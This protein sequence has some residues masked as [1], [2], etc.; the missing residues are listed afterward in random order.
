MDAK[1]NE[2]KLLEIFILTDDFVKSY[3]KHCLPVRAGQRRREPGLAMSEIMTILIYYHHSGYKC[4]EYYYERCVLKDLRSYFPKTPSYTRFVQLIPR[5]L[6]PLYWM[7]QIL[8]RVAQATGIYFVDS[9]KLPVCHNRRIH[10]NKVFKD[11][12]KR[13]KTSTG[14]FFGLKIHLVINNL[15]EVV[16]F[17]I[18]AGNVVD[19]AKEVLDK[20]LGFI[21]GKC[22][23]DKGYISKYFEHFYEQGVELIT[24][25]RKNMKNKPMQWADKMMLY[26]RA[27][28]ES[29]N[30]ILMTVFDID[31]TRHRSPVNAITHVL[32]AVIAYYFYDA[33][34]A[35][36]N[37]CFLNALCK[38][39]KTH[40]NLKKNESTLIP[41][42]NFNVDL[43]TVTVDD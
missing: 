18:T 16:S 23:G 1:V 13:G 5:C 32:G 21:Y 39:S 22:F 3:K 6:L 27:I 43:W 15:G 2:Q 30:D 7:G 37:P 8:G 24:R 36:F 35:V 12:A 38:L 11:I 9:K 19:N 26:K 10:S 4:F 42:I 41:D 14:W 33:K 17:V 29:V 31:H 34:P 40:V 25:I 28:I 20:L